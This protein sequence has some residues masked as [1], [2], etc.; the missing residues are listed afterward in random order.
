GHSG[1]DE[2]YRT[3]FGF[4][5]EKKAA[6]VLMANHDYLYTGVAARALLGELFEIKDKLVLRTPIHL[7]LRKHI[8]GPNGIEKCKAIYREAKEKYPNQYYLSGGNL[9][10]LGYMLLDRQKY[11]AARDIFLFN[12]ELFPEEAGFYDSVG[13][14]YRAEGKDEEALNWYRKALAKDKSLDFTKK[15]IKEMTR[16]QKP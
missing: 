3:Y 6:V 16:D 11:Q 13:D 12:I 10:N 2:G 7:E 1:G 14:A 4:V 9:D 8:L 15:K 5:P